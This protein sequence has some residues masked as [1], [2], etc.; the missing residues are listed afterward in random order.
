MVAKRTARA[1]RTQTIN[2]A[3]SLIV[4]GPDGIRTR[5]TGQ[6][7]AELVAELAVLRP[8]RAAL[9]RAPTEN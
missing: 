4:T 2:Q 6:T 1:Q 7:P 3:R 5:L 9:S 8:G